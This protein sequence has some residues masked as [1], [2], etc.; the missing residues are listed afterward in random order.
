MRMNQKNSMVLEL[1]EEIIRSFKL[2]QVQS[3][4]LLFA[5]ELVWGIVE[6]M[7]WYAYFYSNKQMKLFQELWNAYELLM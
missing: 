2:T 1:Q 6:I 4:K 5:T 3:L 7:K